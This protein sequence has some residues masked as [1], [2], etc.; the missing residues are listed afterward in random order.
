LQ[1]ALSDCNQSLDLEPNNANSRDS[2]AFVYMKMGKVE[3][4][5]V[6]YNMALRLNPGL[7]TS[8][9]GRDVA[10]Q[11]KGDFA[12]G[13]SDIESAKKI[14]LD[15]AEEFHR[16]GIDLKQLSQSPP[17]SQTSRAHRSRQRAAR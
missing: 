10:K 17:R 12:Q 16:Y 2:R 15:I 8:L 5:I 9:Y 4:A 1:G 3:D 6:D 14:Q 13:N 7:A 11:K